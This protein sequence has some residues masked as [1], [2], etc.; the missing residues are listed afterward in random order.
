M[1]VTTAEKIR[2]AAQL[3]AAMEIS[4]AHWS[5]VPNFTFEAEFDRW[6]ETVAATD[7]RR[8]FSLATTKFMAGLRNGHTAFDDRWLWRTAGQPT[9]F[10]L[11]KLQNTWVVTRSAVPDLLPGDCP[12]AIAGE[13]ISIWADR[14]SPYVSASTDWSRS[15]AIF[16][17]YYLLPSTF[18]LELEGGRRLWIERGKWPLERT[19]SPCLVLD[20]IPI[21]RIPSFAV[22][23][24]EDEAIKMV[25][26]VSDRS[27]LI[28][29]LRGNG[30]GDTPTRLL[31]SLM[32]RSYT[33]WAEE[34]PSHSGLHYAFGERPD[35]IHYA[36][37]VTEP[38][39][40]AFRGNIAILADASTGSAAEDFLA[41]FKH[42]G[43]AI[44]VGRT[45]S[46]SSGQ[47]FVRDFG[48]D[49]S[50]RVGSKREMFPDGSQFE[51][52][53]IAPD[54]CVELTPDDIRR[55]VD[56]DHLRAIELLSA[57]SL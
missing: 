16:S 51:G 26:K 18:E 14:I 42:N 53:G 12:A 27:A 52:V 19:M 4:F 23:A 1:E 25:S 40:T 57:R 34:T 37:R 55:G 6:I 35:P 15:E 9:G 11:R 33:S 32:D 21:L 10:T 44:I 39:S 24:Y 22:P 36:A 49:M 17:R 20:P 3:R 13:A 38:L 45:T 47:P 56:Q 48:N 5:N 30:G 46:G 41:P 28:I 54:V 7:S 29:D 2:V 8:D 50:L 31:A 43:R